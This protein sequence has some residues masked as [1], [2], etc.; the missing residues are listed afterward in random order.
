MN[1]LPYITFKAAETEYK[2]KF[3]A[4]ASVELEKKLGGSLTENYAKMNEVNVATTFLWAALKKFQP[5][6][7]LE[8]AYQIYDDFIDAGGTLEEY[9]E[10]MLEVLVISGFFKKEAVEKI[11]ETEALMKRLQEKAAQDSLDKIK[12][13][14][15]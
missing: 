15:K 14:Q 12:A 2:L 7:K 8:T 10:I 4:L 9:A 13:A 1:N 3:S 5:E 11:K 6:T